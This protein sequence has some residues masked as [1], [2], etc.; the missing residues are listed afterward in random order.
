[1]LKLRVVKF[2][3]APRQVRLACSIAFTRVCE[4][5]LGLLSGA[6]LNDLNMRVALGKHSECPHWTAFSAD[7]KGF[8]TRSASAGNLSF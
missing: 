1:M 5:W 7:E 8:F 2:L 4:G 6:R 3:E